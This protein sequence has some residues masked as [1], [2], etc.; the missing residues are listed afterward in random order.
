MDDG[1]IGGLVVENNFLIENSHANVNFDVG[2]NS[3]FLADTTYIGGI[4]ADNNVSGGISNPAINN[5]FA[6]RYIECTHNS[7]DYLQLGGLVGKLTTGRIINSY[8]GIYFDPASVSEV[9][10]RQDKGGLVGY[11][12]FS[13]AIGN[14][15]YD[16]FGFGTDDSSLNSVAYKYL[17]Q[18]EAYEE[19][20]N[21]TD[22]DVWNT[23][24]NYNYGMPVL[25]DLDYGGLSTGSGTE[26]NPYLIHHAGRLDWIRT[27]LGSTAYFEQEKDIDLGLFLDKNT[28][29]TPIGTSVASTDDRFGGTFNRFK[30]I[31]DAQNHYINRLEYVQTSGSDDHVNIGLFRMLG[32]AGSN[33]DTGV[34]NLSLT[35]VN[36]SI[37]S[38]IDI[39]N[40]YG[41]FDEIVQSELSMGAIAGYV[42]DASIVNCIITG[43]IKNDNDEDYNSNNILNI[44]AVAGKI[45]GSTI[46][47]V[48]SEAY[49][50]AT[51]GNVGGLIGSADR[52]GVSIDYSYIQ[53]SGNSGSIRLEG[54]ES[55]GDNAR[56]GGIVGFASWT[57][58]SNVANNGTITAYLSGSNDEATDIEG[59]GGIVG[60][61]SYGSISYC[62]N[63]APINY[64][65]GRNNGNETKIGGIIGYSYS[66][67]GNSK[68]INEGNITVS[69]K[70]TQAIVGGISGLMEG[71]G[72]DRISNSRNSGNLNVTPYSSTYSD[73]WLKVGGLAGA[74]L[75]A[76]KDMY[77]SYNEGEVYVEGGGTIMWIGGLIGNNLGGIRGSYNTGSVE[78]IAKYT[79]SSYT[80]RAAYIGGIAGDCVEGITT[81]FNS[82]SVKGSSATTIG[83]EKVILYI[84][85]LTGRFATFSSDEEITKSYNT[86]LVKAEIETCA[87]SHIEAGG[88]V[89]HNFSDIENC[90]NQGNVIATHYEQEDW[91]LDYFND[92]IQIGGIVGEATSFTR[93]VDYSYNSGLIGDTREADSDDYQSV[94]RGAIV[95]DG[96]TR[97]YDNNVFIL[98]QIMDYYQHIT[99]GEQSVYIGSYGYEYTDG[100]WDASGTDD[101]HASQ[102]DAMSNGKYISS[103]DNESS[104]YGWDFDSI[105]DI[106]ENVSYPTLQSVTV[107]GALDSH[108]TD[109]KPTFNPLTDI[110]L[111]EP[112]EF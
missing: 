112:Y 81:S 45:I 47:K 84:G 107:E 23:Y 19:F 14:S 29:F 68:L 97:N 100:I 75:E 1:K 67:D 110:P 26:S 30:G 55:L 82:A 9:N 18:T 25:M 108:M 64:T 27:K 103:M 51:H 8:S 17:A 96:D 42:Q 11:K 7:S 22:L 86:G 89:G 98:R 83:D 92:T 2:V 87:S 36:L 73:T 88:I 94:W 109:D 111:S 106:V 58:L 32:G 77:L 24:H 53:N 5:S 60:S 59:M 80:S 57:H 72:L 76:N 21:E 44:G 16:Y 65:G 105:W 49:V 20:N 41:P 31:Y 70:E 10:S 66:S 74:I 46:D 4:A 102:N 95:G 15:Y 104:Y 63:F 56:I 69:Y 40:E 90:Y 71:Y 50:T 61:I 99:Y 13:Y 6:T 85:G 48:Y 43:T 33:A 52:D 34:Y 12:G 39:D 28:Y 78:F 101:D 38:G 91:G 62:D 3:E 93:E 54:D 35:N 37:D 79:R